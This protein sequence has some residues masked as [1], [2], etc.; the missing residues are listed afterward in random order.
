MK[1]LDDFTAERLE[2]IAERTSGIMPT[3]REISALAR[4]ALAAKTAEPVTWWTG[5]EPVDEMES[6][7]DH[8]TGSHQIPLVPALYA[9]P[10]VN[11]PEL[12][13]G[14]IPCAERMPVPGVVVLVYTP[15]Q[16]GDYPEDV[17]IGFDFIDPDGDD[18]TFW[19]EHGENYEHFCCVAGGMEGCTGPSEK[20]P[21]T[22]WQPLPAPPTTEK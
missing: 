3:M 2:R 7:H 15:P 5:P 20:A 14:W 17:R 12:P 8:E 9:A 6:F 18:P 1:E 19:Y 22:H 21:Y 4:I 11:S 16:P 13:D 10:T